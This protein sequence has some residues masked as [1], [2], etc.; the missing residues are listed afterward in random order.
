MEFFQNV[1]KKKDWL[2]LDYAWVNLL[3]HDLSEI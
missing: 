1:P 3:D 2:H